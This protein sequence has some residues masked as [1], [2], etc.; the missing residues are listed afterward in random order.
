MDRMQSGRGG[1]GRLFNM[2]PDYCQAARQAIGT[3]GT[4]PC[5]FRLK[6]VLADSYEDITTCGTYL[7]NRDVTLLRANS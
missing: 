6:L 7:G 4:Y 3:C 1:C 2:H 5:N